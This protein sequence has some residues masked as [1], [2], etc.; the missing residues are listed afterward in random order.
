MAPG[1]VARL[2]AN[3]DPLERLL[4]HTRVLILDTQPHLVRVAKLSDVGY[5]GKVARVYDIPRIQSELQAPIKKQELS[6]LRGQIPLVPVVT[7]TVDSSQGLTLE[8]VGID[9]RTSLW[10]H[11]HLYVAFTR[12]TSRKGMLVVVTKDQVESARPYVC[13]KGR[14]RATL[15][16][17]QKK[18]RANQVA[19]VRTTN[20]VYPELLEGAA[21]R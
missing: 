21:S 17:A 14:A 2:V 15:S 11:G 9:L 1:M 20:V 6:S 7:G 19:R 12:C 16:V 3:L 13:R 10:Q 18:C 4:K 8:R 5:S